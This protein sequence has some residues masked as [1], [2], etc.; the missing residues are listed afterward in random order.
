MGEPEGIFGALFSRDSLTAFGATALE[1]DPEEK[2]KLHRAA[3]R[4]HG[5][6]IEL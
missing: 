1:L 6:K 5:F 2:V 3:A 4:A